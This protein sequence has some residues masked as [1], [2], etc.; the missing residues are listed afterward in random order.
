MDAGLKRLSADGAKAERPLDELEVSTMRTR[1]VLE[2]TARLKL[3]LE[4]RKHATA[5]GDD[6]THD[7]STAQLSVDV[8]ALEQSCVP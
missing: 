2:G 1:V 6:S 3:Q 4:A 8:A 7:G 5:R